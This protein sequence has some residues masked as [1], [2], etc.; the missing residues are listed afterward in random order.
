MNKRGQAWLD[1]AMAKVRA[2]HDMPKLDCPRGRVAKTCT[3]FRVQ[4][5]NPSARELNSKMHRPPRERASEDCTASAKVA[6]D[7][8]KPKHPARA[9]VQTSVVSSNMLRSLRWHG[10]QLSPPPYGTGAM[11]PIERT[12]YSARESCVARLGDLSGRK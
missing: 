12:E 5:P 4:R 6:P 10:C 7:S 3:K 8:S 11:Q 1:A 2:G 9:S